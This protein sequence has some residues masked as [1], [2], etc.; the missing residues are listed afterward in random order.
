MRGLNFVARRDAMRALVDA[1][2]I[3][4]ICLQERKMVAIS[5]QLILSMLGSDFDNNY[6]CHPLVGASGGIMIA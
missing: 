1:A 3:D 6:I 2:K 5:H 4:I